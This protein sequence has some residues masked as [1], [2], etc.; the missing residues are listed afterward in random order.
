MVSPRA[1]EAT[2]TIVT[3]P[4]IAASSL[5][6][7]APS[8]FRATVRRLSEDDG[9]A[10]AAERL[11]IH[12]G[13]LAQGRVRLDGVHQD[14][15]EVL[16]VTT[17]VR[18]PPELVGDLGRAARRLH[19]AHALHLLP[20]EGLV[21]PE[22][23]DRRLVGLNV[24]VHTDDRALPGVLLE[25]RAVARVGDLLLREPRIERPDHPAQLVDLPDQPPGL[26]LHAIGERLD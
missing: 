19:G 4:T 11:A 7:T 20:L 16:A 2:A 12:V 5:P 1:A 8:S 13:D 18:D 22:V 25:L 10:I 3:N 15:H 9:L 6:L 24:A 14:R 23:R 26:G 17:R 21:E